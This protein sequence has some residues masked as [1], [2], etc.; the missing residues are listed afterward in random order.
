MSGDV[1]IMPF[2]SERMANSGCQAVVGVPYK[3]SYLSFSCHM[4]PFDRR[5]VR[6]AVAAAID[7]DRLIEAA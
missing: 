5:V 6:R 3:A 4:P 7:K 1:D 2:L